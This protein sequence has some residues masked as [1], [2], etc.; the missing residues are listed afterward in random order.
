MPTQ[1]VLQEMGEYEPARERVQREATLEN[2]VPVLGGGIPKDAPH[3]SLAP[4]L[5]FRKTD[6]MF[7][8]MGV[9]TILL[10]LIWRK[11]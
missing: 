3:A 6:L 7:V 5:Q 9:Q 8:L 10:Y 1:D 4:I 2:Q 11:L